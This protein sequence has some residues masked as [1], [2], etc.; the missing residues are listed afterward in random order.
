MLP[1]RLI[2]MMPLKYA[3]LPRGHTIPPSH[4]NLGRSKVMGAEIIEPEQSSLKPKYYVPALFLLTSSL[5]LVSIIWRETGSAAH[6]NKSR[7]L[8]DQLNYVKLYF[9]FP[10]KLNS[11]LSCILL[12]VQRPMME[13]ILLSQRRFQNRSQS[14]ETCCT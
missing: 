13:T 10:S 6:I 8:L 1:C 5:A 4:K 12:P 9:L 7:F 14:T 2:Q 11:V 3:L